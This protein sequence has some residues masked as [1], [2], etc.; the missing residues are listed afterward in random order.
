[1]AWDWTRYE[2]QMSLPGWGREGQE[3]LRQ[4]RVVIAGAGG[5]GSPAAF[6]LVAAGV[7]HI[8]L[9]DADRVDISNLNR[10]ILHTE[11]DLTRSKVE[12]A[13]ERLRALNGEAEVE[14]VQ[15]QINAENAAYLVGDL[16]VVDALD[17]L[18]G[19][20]ALNE[21][22]VQRRLPIF[23]GAIHGF[24]GRATTIFPGETPCLGC[25][26]KGVLP[27]PI[28]AIGAMA[29]VIGSLQAMEVIKYLLGVGELLK[30]RQIVYD[31]LHM[32]FTE[33]KLKRDPACPVCGGI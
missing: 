5:L 29:S 20:L 4:G 12:S 15:E 18:P 32:T 22:A 24:E 25:L 8:R 2:R 9:I 26:Y 1:M 31:G 23:H 21:V 7:G 28:P 3:R 30:N 6:Y 33:V 13:R 16:P 27:G 11:L 14:I 10:Q 19:R 17:N